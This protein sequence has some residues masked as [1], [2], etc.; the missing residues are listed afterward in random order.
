[1]TLLNQIPRGHV[2]AHLVV[3]HHLVALEALNGTVDHHG[4]N[5]QM[6]HFL[7]QGAIVGELVAHHQ[8]DAVD[9]ARHQL[10]QQF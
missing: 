6:A 10:A 2:A 1:M 8:K 4:R 7:A 5:R 9:A 3:E